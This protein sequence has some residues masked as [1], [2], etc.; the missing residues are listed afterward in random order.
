MPVEQADGAEVQVE[1]ARAFAVVAREDT[2][3]A[4]V[5]GHAL[6]EAEFG[7]EIG[8]E[9]VALALRA[10]GSG[11]LGAQPAVGV[12][13]GEVGFELLV[14]A[15]EFAQETLVASDFLQAGLPGKLEHAQR[16]VVGLV[17]EIDVEFAEEA[18]RRGFPAPPEVVDD[19][20][21]RLEGR[22]QL[23]DDVEGLDR[24]VHGVMGQEAARL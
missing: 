7:G 11:G 18:A 24:W 15:A 2:Q 6:V 22:R 9:V 19:L 23:G 5:V 13:A 8:D 3:A 16:V 20:P 4:R 14:D 1:V 12:G 10:G 17:P 21:Q